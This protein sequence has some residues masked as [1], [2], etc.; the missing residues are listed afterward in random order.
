MRSARLLMA[1]GSCAALLCSLASASAAQERSRERAP[2]VRVYSPDGAVASNYVTPAIGVSEDAYVF[3][4]MMDLDGRIQVL[5]PEFPG[6]SVRV[7]SD[8]QLQLPNFFAGYNAPMQ[9]APRYT[10][11]GLA[12]YDNY[13]DTGNDT[14]GTVVAI[15][16]RAPFKLELIET[17]GDWNISQIRRLIEH[18][19]PSSAAQALAQYIGAKGEPIGR[20]YMRFAGERQSYYAYDDYAYCGYGGYGYGSPYRGVDRALTFARAAQLRSL[21]LRPVFLGYDACG[22][23]VIAVAPFSGGGGIVL[24]PNRLPRRDIPNRLPRRDTTVFPKSHFPR[25]I[26]GHPGSEDATPRPVPVGIF[27][28]P[29]QSERRTREVTMPAPQGRR[30]E[31][32]DV[33]DQFRP[34]PANPSFPNRV[35]AP[36]EQ[37]VSPRTAPAAIG[38][39]PIQR[40]QPRVIAA[41]PPPPP[42]TVPS[43]PPPKQR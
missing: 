24:P 12:S 39:F 7:R 21:G 26:A 40:S 36:V 15:A 9:D 8:K 28:L 42:K 1:A 16:S 6:I 43:E 18:R 10:S 25:G 41:P 34:Q 11:R 22:L 2:I 4:V 33:S 5:H 13:E 20:D 27:P 3:A 35:R 31:P 14:R 23:P 29:Q 38:V 32:R 17:N 30:A 19:T 37:T